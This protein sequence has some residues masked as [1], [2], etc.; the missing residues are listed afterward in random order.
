MLL[1]G[2]LILV[3]STVEAS[4][5]QPVSD[6][7]PYN[8]Q[9]TAAS[10]LETTS[11]ALLKSSSFTPNN[12]ALSLVNS[13]L[14]S[15]HNLSTE[16]SVRCDAIYGRNLNHQSCI[17]ALKTLKFDNLKQFT[18]GPRGTGVYYYYPMPRRFVSLDGTCYFEAIVYKGTS[19]VASMHDV[20]NGA[21]A[22]IVKCIG[23]KNPSEGGVAKDFGGENRL[24]LFTASS[25]EPATKVRCYGSAEMTAIVNSCQTIMDRMD[26][27]IGAS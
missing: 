27:I 5:L 14:A 10:P 11:S 2:L 21:L 1:C 23:E 22:V 9:D 4:V 18:W 19:A 15:N 7:S 6:P 16:T 3:L 25:L 26:E 8:A 12:R 17:S 20:A 24:A 13:S